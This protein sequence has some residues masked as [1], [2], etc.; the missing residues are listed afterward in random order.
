MQATIV[1]SRQ[2]LAGLG[3]SLLAVCGLAQSHS[4]CVSTAQ[5]FQDALT[6][7]S[8]FHTYNLEDNVV[9]LVHGVYKTGVATG[10]TPFFFYSPN[11]PHSMRIYGGYEDGCRGPTKQTPPTIL[12]GNGTTGVL[13]LRDTYGDIVVSNLTLQNG[14]SDEVGGGLQVNYS[15]SVNGSVTI[16]DTIIRN[17]HS[18]VDAGGL[19]ASGAGIA[20]EVVGNLIEGNRADA[21]YG[22]GYVSGFG[23]NELNLVQNNTVTQNTSGAAS[24]PVGGLFCGGTSPCRISNN[25]FITNTA[26]GLY[27]GDANA[28]VEFNDY[29]TLGG[30]APALS[31]G[32][33]SVNP[34]FVDASAGNFHLTGTSPLLGVSPYPIYINDLDGNPFT[35]TGYGKFDLGAYAETI[36]IDGFDAGG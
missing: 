24:N 1:H 32:N 36:F 12:D 28:E 18:T 4:F 30:T 33:V 17:N 35:T 6:Q 2:A 16:Q 11:S 20:V 9:V 13:V 14:E 8:S 19:Y 22:A 10:N 7:S 34:Q 5:E 29:G 15:V 27:L 3:I 31:A 21:L 23:T 26:V 25:I